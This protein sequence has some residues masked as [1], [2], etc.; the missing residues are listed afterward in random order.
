MLT[1]K[2][3]V[4]WFWLHFPFL[5]FQIWQSKLCKDG[6][7]KAILEVSCGVLFCFQKCSKTE[8]TGP[9]N[10][11]YSQDLCFLRFDCFS[12]SLNVGWSEALGQEVSL[13]PGKILVTKKTTVWAPSIYLNSAPCSDC[14][15]ISGPCH[16][17]FCAPHPAV[18]NRLGLTQDSLL[19][20]VLK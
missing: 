15:G 4:P 19:Q 3:K 17:W 9:V 1:W 8:K 20:Q 12:S 16:G 14:G 2:D 11:C 5:L 10:S 6:R 18:T 7:G 13:G